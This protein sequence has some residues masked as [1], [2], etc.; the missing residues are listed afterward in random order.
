MKKI[1][2]YYFKKAKQENYPARSVYK[3]QEIQKQCS[4]LGPGQTVLD[5]GAAPGSW[6]LFAAEKVGLLGR[7]LAVDINPPA[8]SFPSQVTF[9]EDDAFSPGPELMAAL[10][11]HAPF[12]VVVSDMAPKTTG[13]KFA[14]QANSLELCQRALEMARAFLKP[15]GRFVAKIFQGPDVKAFEGDMRASFATVKAIKPK[16]SRPESKEIFY[17]GLGFRP[18]DGGVRPGR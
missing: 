16:S 15:G 13:I 1:Q 10:A 9:V 4:L 5:L 11:D 8:V 14:D 18:A 3:L 7:V 6:T 17:V 2:D 12:D